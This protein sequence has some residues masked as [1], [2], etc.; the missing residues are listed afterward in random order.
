M[1]VQ[2]E[3]SVLFIADIP[4]IIVLVITQTVYAHVVILGRNVGIF[5]YAPRV[6]YI[7]QLQYAMYTYLDHHVVKL[8]GT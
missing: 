8:V 2:K 4:V 1:G 5:H 6:K 3:K 7:L